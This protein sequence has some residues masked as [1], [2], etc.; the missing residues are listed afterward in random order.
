MK[1]IEKINYENLKKKNIWFLIQFLNIIRDKLATS[2][3]IF[4]INIF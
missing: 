2:F 3:M 1:I 4:N